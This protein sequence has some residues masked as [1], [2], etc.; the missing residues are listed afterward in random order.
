MLRGFSINEDTMAKELIK[1]VG[2]KGE[3]LTHP[4]TSKHM[5]EHQNWPKLFNRDS[6][7]TWELEG[8]KPIDEIAKERAKAMIQAP[9][10][11]PLSD[12]ILEELAYIIKQ[13]EKELGVAK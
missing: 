3:F 4:H 10:L 2:P 8:S 6:A 5:R 1:E 12:S 13:A 9:N 11:L 7:T